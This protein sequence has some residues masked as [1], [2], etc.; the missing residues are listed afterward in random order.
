VSAPGFPERPDRAR[1]C[2][3]QLLPDDPDQR[4]LRARDRRPAAG[5]LRRDGPARDREAAVQGSV[6]RAACRRHRRGHRAGHSLGGL[7]PSGRRLPRPAGQ[8]VRA[9]HER[10]GRQ[11]VAD[12]G[13]RPGATPDSGTR[14]RQA[15]A[16]PAARREEAAD[17]ARQGRCLRASRRRRSRAGR[18]DRHPVPADVDGQGPA[19]RH[20]LAVCLGRALVRAAGSRRRAAGRCRA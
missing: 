19:A 9:D 2:D 18:E 14:L 8:A 5:R 7:R 17:P 16:R 20:A 3:D 4:L 11:E 1:K 15:R 10:R 13:R 6:P 12:Q